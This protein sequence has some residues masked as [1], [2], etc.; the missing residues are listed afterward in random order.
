MFMYQ[1]ISQN[2]QTLVI[3]IAV[4]DL[5]CSQQVHLKNLTLCGHSDTVTIELV[6]CLLLIL[7]GA[8]HGI[9]LAEWG[10]FVFQF[11]VL[12]TTPGECVWMEGADQETYT[13]AVPLHSSKHTSIGLYMA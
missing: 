9:V 11:T 5:K 1:A 7:E 4:H 3:L 2:V 8:A 10:L 13:H 6:S 12:A